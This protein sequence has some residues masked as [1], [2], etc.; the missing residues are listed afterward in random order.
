MSEGA[1]K[2][3]RS[4][5]QLVSGSSSDAKEH[6]RVVNGAEDRERV[7]E[8]SGNETLTGEGFAKRS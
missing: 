2:E 3:S 4:I 8:D 5:N 1:W 7:L 6:H